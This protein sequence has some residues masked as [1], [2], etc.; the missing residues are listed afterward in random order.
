M[1]VLR[2]TGAVPPQ[3]RHGQREHL[4]A[5]QGVNRALDNPAAVTH[6]MVEALAAPHI[7]MVGTAAETPVATLARKVTVDKDTLLPGLQAAHTPAAS[8]R[9]GIVE[10]I[11]RRVQARPAATAAVVMAVCLVAIALVRAV[12]IEAVDTLAAAP[13]I[14]VE[15]V[16][17]AV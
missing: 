1:R 14:P 15:A 8:I 11:A 17:P 3:K 9:W 6:A 13:V 16:V 10:A 2:I 12:V 7:R 4:W 5:L